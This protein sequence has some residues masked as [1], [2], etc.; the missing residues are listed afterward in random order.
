MRHKKSY[1]QTFPKLLFPL[2][3]TQ[4]QWWNFIL[5][6]CGA[7]PNIMVKAKRTF[8]CDSKYLFIMGTQQSSWVYTLTYKKVQRSS[9]ESA[10]YLL[11]PR[12]R[13]SGT[14]NNQASKS[15]VMPGEKKH[16][17][18]TSNV[19]VAPQ[20]LWELWRRRKRKY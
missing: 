8:L 17:L 12:R 14:I 16:L 11:F 9:K 20:L 18:K 19:D 10:P 15:N 5:Y 1:Q 7:I 13:D 4:C 6:L 3:K 2:K